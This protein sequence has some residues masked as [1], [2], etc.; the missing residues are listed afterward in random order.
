MKTMRKL[1]EL[2]RAFRANLPP[3]IGDRELEAA[4]IVC[5]CIAIGAVIVLVALA[6]QALA[7]GGR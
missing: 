1:T 5:G 7:G 2:W 4:I 3:E 6:A